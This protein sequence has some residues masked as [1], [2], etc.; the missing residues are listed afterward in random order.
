MSLDISLKLFVDVGTT[1]PY[2]VLLYSD[3]Y[4]HNV[5]PM[6][7][8]AGVWEALYESDG[9]QAAELISTL[10]KG[11]EAMRASPAAYC[12]LNPSN[13]WGDYSGALKFLQAFTD[14]CKKFPKALVWVSR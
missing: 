9:Q 13:R 6:W 4:T 3:N 10:E 14:A 2:E 7:E 11:Y 5:C 12:A 8:L 1:E